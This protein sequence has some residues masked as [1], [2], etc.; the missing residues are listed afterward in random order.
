MKNN[1]WNNYRY[2][3]TL[4]IICMVVLLWAG[5]GKSPD[6]DKTGTGAEDGSGNKTTEEGSLQGSE[7]E[8]EDEED[9]EDDEEESERRKNC[10][11]K[12]KIV[13]AAI[14]AVILTGIS[15]GLRHWLTGSWLPTENIVKEETKLDEAEIYALISPLPS[16]QPAF[17]ADDTYAAGGIREESIIK[18]PVCG[19]KRLLYTENN[20]LYI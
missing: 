9:E 1:K 8:A 7:T 14:G 12:G 3:L 19:S 16:P 2:S 4:G 10:S 15:F 6:S 17:T 5:C 13:V 18:D 20:K 11:N